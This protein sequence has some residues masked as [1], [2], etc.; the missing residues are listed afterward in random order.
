MGDY[1]CKQDSQRCVQTETGDQKFC[2]TK[3]EEIRCTDLM[4][5]TEYNI[6]LDGKSMCEMDEN[7]VRSECFLKYDYRNC[8][9]SK[10]ELD[11]SFYLSL[12]KRKIEY[13]NLDE[14]GVCP[15]V[16]EVSELF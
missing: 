7:G 10:E 12:I 6:D 16:H 4:C 9:G 8:K 13:K 2:K 5:D 1:D 14:R 3:I 11:R 15:I